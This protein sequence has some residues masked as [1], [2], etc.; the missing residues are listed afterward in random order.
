VSPFPGVMHCGGMLCLGTI[1]SW[2]LVPSM[3]GSEHGAAR[4]AHGGSGL[5]GH[6]AR[7]QLVAGEGA[8]AG[9]GAEGAGGCGSGATDPEAKGGLASKVSLPRRALEQLLQA[10]IQLDRDGARCLQWLL[11]LQ[12]GLHTQHHQIRPEAAVRG[13][14]GHAARCGLRGVHA[15][16]VAGPLRRG[17][18]CG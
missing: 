1:P 17:L 15:V 6:H 14:L 5:A 11:L 18:C 10:P 12:P 3:W 2:V 8:W 16:A 7:L 4:A 9:L 13:C